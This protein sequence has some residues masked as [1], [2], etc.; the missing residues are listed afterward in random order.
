MNINSR[1]VL[2]LAAGLLFLGPAVAGE[3]TPESTRATLAKW[4]ETQQLIAKEK[5]DWQEG[6]EIL[7]S[8][9]DVVKGEIEALRVKLGDARKAAAEGNA[10]R[11]ETT[12]EST[13]LQATGVALGDWAAELEA[14]L[15]TLKPRLPEPLQQKVKPLF[16]RMPVEARTTQVSLA[17]RFQNIAGILNEVQKWN[18][19][20][21]L[22]TEVRTLADGRPAEVRTVYV[23]L[24]Q[25]YFVSGGGDAGIGRPG[26]QGWEWTAANEI[27]PQVAE[28]VEV[29]QSKAKP[30]FVPLPVKVQ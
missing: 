19:E 6:K 14:G 17:E 13:A 3:A 2:A 28:A 4:V 18:G 26:A 10:K 27:A 1:R 29:L 7:R 24:A 16:D 25:A 15:K 9:I 8:R 12:S 21:T 11:S 22:A 23:G 20:I 5:K 30:S